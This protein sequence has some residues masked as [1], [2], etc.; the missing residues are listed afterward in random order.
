MPWRPSAADCRWRRSTR[1]STSSG[2]KAPWYTDKDG[3][4]AEAF[5]AGKG[6][7]LNVFIRDDDDRVYRTYM[8]K[9]R[10][11][12]LFDV[13]FKLMDLTPWGRQE[14]WEDSPEGRPQSAPYEWWRMHDEYE[15]D[16]G[17]A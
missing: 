4:F 9:N 6:F 16:P 14:C 8:T 10:G 3:K 12:E 7:A 11:V 5:E 2:R 17:T 15:V 13:H 1:H